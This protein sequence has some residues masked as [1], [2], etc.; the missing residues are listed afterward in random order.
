MSLVEVI[1][2]ESPKLRHQK[3][4]LR[5]M[6]VF[7]LFLGGGLCLGAWVGFNGLGWDNALGC[8]VAMVVCAIPFL[9]ASGLSIWSARRSDFPRTVTLSDRVLIVSY[10]GMPDERKYT[11]DECTWFEG[12]TTHDVRLENLLIRKPAIIIELPEKDPLERRLACG[13]EPE[14]FEL[15]RLALHNEGCRQVTLIE[16]LPKMFLQLSVFLGLF[17]GSVFAWSFGY[18]IELTAFPLPGGN[19]LRGI[20]GLSLWQFVIGTLMLLQVRLTPMVDRERNR[21]NFFGNLVY[22]LVIAG[23]FI[24]VSGQASWISVL[25]CTLFWIFLFFGVSRRILKS[26]ELASTQLSP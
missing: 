25:L 7:L 18:W 3:R 17:P 11:L 2:L 12:R 24:G 8:L 13:L 23:G 20:L 14:K 1:D 4:P 22:L 19:P 16:R 26:G 15:W 9:A 6:G 5:T 21:N 10:A